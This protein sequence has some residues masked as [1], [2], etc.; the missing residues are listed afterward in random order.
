MRHD[1]CGKR[2]CGT[3]R[4]AT[5]N[6]VSQDA[7]ARNRRQ[8]DAA[9]RGR[10]WWV[11]WAVLAVVAAI[12]AV[13]IA[14]VWDQ[15]AKA[16]TSLYSAKWWWLLAAALAAAASIHSFAQIQRTLLKSAGVHVKQWR[17]EAAYYAANSLSTTLPGGRYSQPRFCFDSNDSGVRRRWWHRG[18]W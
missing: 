15:L 13:E 16:W 14:L 7:P 6:H 3:T 5:L 9:A 1:A 18:S 2:D 11:R 12:L 17:S 4:A 10:Y 8:Q